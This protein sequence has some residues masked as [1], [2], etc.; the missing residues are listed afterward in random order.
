MKAGYRESREASR[1]ATCAAMSDFFAPARGDDRRIVAH[2]LHAN[3][4]D[5]NP[6]EGQQLRRQPT[7]KTF[8]TWCVVAA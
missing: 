5:M 3:A 8:R 2:G 1:P 7:A 6:R 4:P